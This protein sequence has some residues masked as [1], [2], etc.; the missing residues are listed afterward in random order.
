MPVAYGLAAADG[1]LYVST[2]S[3]AIHCYGP[4]AGAA[5]VHRPPAVDVPADPR[6]AAA[7]EEIVRRTGVSEGYCVDLACGDGDL[8]LELARR[9]QLQIVAIDADPERVAEARRKLDAAGYYGVR[10]RCTAATRPASTIPNGLRIWSSPA[11]RWRKEP[12]AWSGTR[13]AGCSVRTAESPAWGSR[14]NGG[15]G[16]RGPPEHAG[17]WTH[18]YADPANTLCSSDPSG[19]L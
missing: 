3:G 6:A 8:A 15:I 7:A 16:S 2:A 9:T 5:K 4:P 11:A 13:C 19:A 18:L 1:C 12:A 10:V 17:Q 14:A